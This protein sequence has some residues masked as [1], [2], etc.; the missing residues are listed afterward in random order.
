V[1]KSQDV[2]ASD[3]ACS[4]ARAEI[5]RARR[6]CLTAIGNCY[7]HPPEATPADVLAAVNTLLRV[8]FDLGAE[9]TRASLLPPPSGPEVIS[10][11][12][13]LMR[14]LRRG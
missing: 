13:T 10:A 4:E 12:E 14:A 2:G 7:G 9:Y 1:S 8:G 11:A 5:Q 6:A 3:E